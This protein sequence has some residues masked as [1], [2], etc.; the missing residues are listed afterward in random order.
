MGWVGEM[1]WWDGLVGLDDL[2]G[3]VKSSENSI[4]NWMV[5][6]ISV[7]RVS[8]MRDVNLVGEKDG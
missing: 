8:R 5:G 7:Y 4:N 1:G 3:W 6:I 2:R